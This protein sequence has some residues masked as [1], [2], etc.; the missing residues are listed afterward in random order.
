MRSRW[1]RCLVGGL[2]ALLFGSDALAAYPR[3]SMTVSWWRPVVEG[4]RSRVIRAR[5]SRKEGPRLTGKWARP[6]RSLANGAE[7]LLQVAR[8]QPEDPEQLVVERMPFVRGAAFSRDGARYGFLSTQS[9]A[10]ELVL[11]RSRRVI[12][13]PFKIGQSSRARERWWSAPLRVENA[14]PLR[15]WLPLAL[16]RDT[17]PDR[18]VLARFFGRFTVLCGY[19][20]DGTVNSAGRE[21]PELPV[22]GLPKIPALWGAS[23]LVPVHPLDAPPPPHTNYQLLGGTFFAGF[24]VPPSRLQITRSERLEL[25]THAPHN[26]PL[27]IAVRFVEFEGELTSGPQY[28]RVSGFNDGVLEVHPTHAL[29]S[30]RGPRYHDAE[31]LWSDALSDEYPAFLESVR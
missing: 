19:L 20:Y 1:S 24:S 14:G 11:N 3:P 23:V 27:P 13:F 4:K 31:G 9:G 10:N 12:E 8:L 21:I 26:R 29:P 30:P 2:W 16:G 18:E 15:T 5:L 7:L 25:M 17:E 22:N 6:L 28:L